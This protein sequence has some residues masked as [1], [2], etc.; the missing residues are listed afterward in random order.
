MASPWSPVQSAPPKSPGLGMGKKWFPKKNSDIITMRMGYGCWEVKKRTNKN[1]MSTTSNHH[2]H[3]ELMRSRCLSHQY[4]NIKLMKCCHQIDRRALNW[5]LKNS[6]PSLGPWWVKLQGSDVEWY[7]H[8]VDGF[9]KA[10][11]IL[12][13]LRSWLP[14]QCSFVQHIFIGHFCE[15]MF[16]HWVCCGEWNE[17]SAFMELTV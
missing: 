9:L 14:R 2:T 8:L 11:C 6:S 4:M 16:W 7:C 12:Q 10:Q 5:I 13:C 1:Q 3:I 15:S 17:W